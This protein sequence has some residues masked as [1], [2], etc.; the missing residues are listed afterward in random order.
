MCVYIWGWVNKGLIRQVSTFSVR[1][2]Q[3]QEVIL[4]ATR[5]PNWQKT[6]KNNR[7][8]AQW[9]VKRISTSPLGMAGLKQSH[10]AL[11]AKQQQHEEGSLIFF[12]QGI[13]IYCCRHSEKSGTD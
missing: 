9:I 7:Y 6:Q 1:Q 13:L 4:N 12:P 2:E 10:L 5:T 11:K 8:I 3:E